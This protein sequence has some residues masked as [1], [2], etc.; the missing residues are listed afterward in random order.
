MEITFTASDDLIERARQAA[1]IRGTTLDQ[2]F[3]RWLA[4]WTDATGGKLPPP[5]QADHPS[6]QRLRAFFERFGDHTF[7]PALT[8]EDRNAR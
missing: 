7:G 3:Q 4:G 8:R 6:A 2:E 5:D 1:A